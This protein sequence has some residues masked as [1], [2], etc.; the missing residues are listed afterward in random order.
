MFSV[1]FSGE[2]LRVPNDRRATSVKQTV[3]LR[4]HT[5]LD[6]NQ[7]IE[8]NCFLLTSTTVRL[9]TI[10][11]K[12][13]SRCVQMHTMR[14]KQSDV[15]FLRSLPF[16]S[17]LEQDQFDNLHKKIRPRIVE[18]GKVVYDI[19]DVSEEMFIIRAGCIA[20]EVPVATE[21]KADIELTEKQSAGSFT[22]RYFKFQKLVVGQRFGHSEM[23][24]GYF[25]SAPNSRNST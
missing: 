18:K 17:K 2:L 21:G 11:K 13:F 15:D 23:L 12:D 3:S 10:S 5:L 19:G 14:S 20:Q 7:A 6:L 22:S 24:E 9:L 16:F 25:D 8:R 1:I 4:Q